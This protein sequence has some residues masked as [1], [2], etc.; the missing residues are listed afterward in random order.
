MVNTRII[1]W[2]ERLL[3]FMWTGHFTEMRSI[4]YIWLLFAHSNEI[5][6]FR[7]PVLN[8][9]FL[10]NFIFFY[11]LLFQLNTYRLLA[12]TGLCTMIHPN[13]CCL[14]SCTFSVFRL[15]F[16]FLPSSQPSFLFFG[17]HWNRFSLLF[18]IKCQKRE[19]WEQKRYSLC[20]QFS[21][22]PVSPTLLRECSALSALRLA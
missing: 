11:A 8:S 12:L 22:L 4:V 19:H 2:S 18:Y 6:N 16:P 5:E 15:L 3:C 17:S 10:L 7:K 1:W 21:F 14:P 13:A 20:C 9:K